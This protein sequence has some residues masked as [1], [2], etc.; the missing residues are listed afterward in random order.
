MTVQ[1]AGKE[2][3]KTAKRIR[4]KDHFSTTYQAASALVL[5]GKITIQN[6]DEARN[7]YDKKVVDF[8]EILLNE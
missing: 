5:N 4:F 8:A 6:L 3:H 1:V 2:E 7:T